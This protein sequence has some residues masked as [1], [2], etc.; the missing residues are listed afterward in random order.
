MSARTR[1]LV[2]AA[3]C[4]V[5]MLGVALLCAG[6]TTTRREKPKDPYAKESKITDREAPKRYRMAPSEQ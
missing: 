3:L 4:I 2:S 1:T 6:C 5:V